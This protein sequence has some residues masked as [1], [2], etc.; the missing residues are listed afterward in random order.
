MSKKLFLAAL[1]TI[2]V[3]GV[4]FYFSPKTQG[5][6]YFWP[7]AKSFLQG[8]IDI[9][10]APNLNELVEHAGRYFVVYPPMPAVVLLPFVVFAPALNQSI[11]SIV[12]AAITVGL[13]FILCLT[14]TKKTWTA[15]VLALALGF[16]SNFFYTSLIGSSWY[17]AH[18][19]A[20]FFL[21][22]ALLL[23]L[24]KKPVWLIGL[25]F[26]AAF[27]SR[28]P[29]F[30]AGP[31]FIYLL[32]KNDKSKFWR[33]LIYFLLGPLVAVL[34]FGLYNFSRFGSTIQTGYSL[35]PGVLD[36][37]WFKY[38]IFSYHYIPDQLRA[39]FLSM[40]GLISRFPFFIPSNASMA[41]WLTT[42]FLLLL[43]GLKLKDKQSWIFLGVALLVAVPSL[44]HGT[45]GFTQFGYRFS[46]DFIIFLLLALIPIIERSSRWL[47]I[48]LI[49]L[50][51]IIN[52]Y[53]VWLFHIG[54][55]NT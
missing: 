2:V 53:A 6:D 15:F 12:I 16:G 8:R 3:F 51:I 33:N 13:F 52:C 39:I 26:A 23:A 7:Q 49:A 37:P 4:Y 30:L 55:F 38:G 34:I 21:V 44:M 9:A 50:S 17:F 10:S 43:A 41:L 48:L 28:L 11:A 46:L 45:I 32:W 36:E 19:C 20:I 1:L 14:L 54:L 35:I 47:V 42:P 18:V 24:A 22:L 5:N 27:L 25:I 31:I 40:P 29:T